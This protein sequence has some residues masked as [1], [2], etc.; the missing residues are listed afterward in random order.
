M[1]K[2]EIK[3]KGI[4]DSSNFKKSM[5]IWRGDITQ[6][7]VDAIVNAANNQDRKSVV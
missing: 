3:R 7:K 1:L 6:L 4:I 5:N 2:N